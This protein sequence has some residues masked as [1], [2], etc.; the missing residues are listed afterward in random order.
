[1]ALSTP[2]DSLPEL[3]ASDVTAEYRRAF[4]EIVALT[5]SF[6]AASLNTPH[7]RCRWRPRKTA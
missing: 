4:L 7:G 2:S 6:G 3:D 1:M 5:D